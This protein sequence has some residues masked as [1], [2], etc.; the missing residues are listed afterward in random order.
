MEHGSRPLFG[1]EWLRRLHLN[2]H[3]IKSLNSEV[4]SID[5]NEKVKNLKP[6]YANVFKSTL[7]KVIGYKAT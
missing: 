5:V 7:G 6:R 3:E 1:R 4:N 2:W